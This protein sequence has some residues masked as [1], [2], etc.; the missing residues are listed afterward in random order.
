VAHTVAMDLEGE[1]EVQEYYGAGLEDVLASAGI[2]SSPALPPPGPDPLDHTGVGVHVSGVSAKSIVV[3]DSLWGDPL[4]EMNKKRKKDDDTLLCDFHGKVCSRGVCK[5]YGKQ[6]REQ[7]KKLK[8]LKDSQER[9]NWRSGNG[10]PNN[11]RGGRGGRGAVR[12][13]RGVPPRGRGGFGRDS[14]PRSPRDGDFC[15]AKISQVPRLNRSFPQKTRLQGGLM[16]S[17]LPG[18]RGL[19]PIAIPKVTPLGEPTTTRGARARWVSLRNP[20]E[21][22]IPIR[23]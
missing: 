20:T 21:S 3:K 16:A 14:G 7:Q 15:H 6:L 5:V 13:M 17:L 2:V 11:G 12:G 23:A 8:E 1:E 18:M 4:E 19:N 22:P 9:Q 10:G